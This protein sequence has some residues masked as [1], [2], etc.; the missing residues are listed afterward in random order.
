MNSQNEGVIVDD[1]AVG[2]TR[3]STKWGVA[4]PAF[5]L[6]M[7]VTTECFIWSRNLLWALVF[8]PIHGIFYLICLKDARSFE[9]LYLWAQTKGRT[10]LL[11]LGYWKSSSYSPLALPQQSGIKRCWK[12]WARGGQ[13]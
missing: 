10:V 7:I 4:Y 13:S 9:L 3:P 12:W 8:I 2:L 1:L 11:T 5:M 6:N